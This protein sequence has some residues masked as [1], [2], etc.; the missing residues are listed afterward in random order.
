MLSWFSRSSKDRIGIDNPSVLS[1]SL[2]AINCATLTDIN[3]LGMTNTEWKLT[4]VIARCWKHRG[5][6]KQKSA[7]FPRSIIFRSQWQSGWDCHSRSAPSQWHNTWDCQCTQRNDKVVEIATVA[8]L[9]LL[10]QNV[11]SAMTIGN[12]YA[13]AL[14][15]DREI[16]ERKLLLIYKFTYIII[17]LW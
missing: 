10:T 14:D 7:R 15:I 1:S 13:G 4:Y 12:K 11:H 2:L 8:P 16:V 17:Y 6:L 5:N 3:V 9:L